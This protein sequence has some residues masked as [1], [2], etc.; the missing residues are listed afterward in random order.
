MKAGDVTFH[1]GYLIHGA[2][3]NKTNKIREAINITYYPD[4]TKI[5]ELNNL[6][7]KYDAEIFLG[8]KTENEIANSE[9][10][11]IVYKKK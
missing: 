9:M 2:T 1:N 4:G 11:P 3:K 7:R 10:N 5:G 8:N 6:S